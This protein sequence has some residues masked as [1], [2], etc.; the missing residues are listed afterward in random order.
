V[1]VSRDPPLS[2]IAVDHLPSLLPR[3]ASEAFSKQ[4]LPS[5]LELERRTE[6]EVWRKAEKVFQEKVAELEK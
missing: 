3:E 6:N 2:V 5:L 1:P 4:L